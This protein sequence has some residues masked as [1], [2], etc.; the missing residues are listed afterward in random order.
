MTKDDGG[1]GMEEI[2]AGGRSKCIDFDHFAE[3]GTR[4]SQKSNLPQMPQ[5]FADYF[6]A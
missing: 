5:I 1:D 2:C 3:N 6:C 4:P